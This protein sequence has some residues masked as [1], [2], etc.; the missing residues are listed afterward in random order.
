MKFYKDG[1]TGTFGNYKKATAIAIA[2]GAAVSIYLYRALRDDEMIAA[3]LD[4]PAKVIITII[5]FIVVT[6]C[7]FIIYRRPLLIITKDKFKFYTGLFSSDWIYL[8]EI[9]KIKIFSD[10]SSISVDIYNLSNL[11]TT[12]ETVALANLAENLIGFLEENLDVEIEYLN[13]PSNQQIKRTDT[14]PLT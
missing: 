11:R 1:S 5:S 3:S 2:T 14:P 4:D 6:L 10:K 9:K 8:K 7:T 13:N 12:F